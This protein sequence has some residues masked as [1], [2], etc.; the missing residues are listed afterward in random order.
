MS[1]G[2]LTTFVAAQAAIV[3]VNLPLAVSPP[4]YLTGS[5]V[6]LATANAKVG[7]LATV[8]IESNTW[9]VS[10]TGPASAARFILVYKAIGAHEPTA[11]PE[12]YK[13]KP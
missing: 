11:A 6:T 8:F 1:Y 2:A 4:Y 10:L 7:A 13:H 5:S 3:I 12:P 9:L